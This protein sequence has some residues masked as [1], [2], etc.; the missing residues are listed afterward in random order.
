M[1]SLQ[2]PVL[3]DISAGAQVFGEDVSGVDIFDAHLKFELASGAGEGGEIVK[4]AFSE[5]LFADAPETDVSGVIFFIN[6][7]KSGTTISKAIQGGILNGKLKQ[8]GQ[9]TFG[10]STGTG[11][12]TTTSQSAGTAGSEPTNAAW[13]K[14]YQAP[15]IPLPNFGIAF[16]S[17]ANTIP[18]L[19]ANQRYYTDP[20]C[21][22][23]GTTFGRALIRLM[24]TSLM[25]HPFAQAFIKNEDQII[26]DI[27]E[28]DI[29]S[30]IDDKLFK[31]KVPNSTAIVDINEVN[32][33]VHDD[34]V[35]YFGDGSSA[36]T[37][38]G[39]AK[40]NADKS[41]GIHNDILQQLYEQLLGSA[42]ERFDLS[43]NGTTH[44]ENIGTDVS[45]N[46][47]DAGTCNPTRL[48]FRADDTMSFYF[49][50][51]VALQMD[52]G[53]DISPQTV[54]DASNTNVN[55]EQAV[56]STYSA[57]ATSLSSIFFNPRHRW[58]SHG[59]SFEDSNSNG[60]GEAGA[61]FSG[62]HLTHGDVSGNVIMT[63]TNLQHTSSSR[64]FFDAHVWRIL[65]K[66]T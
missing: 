63:G 40:A 23:D 52:D 38:T 33:T 13:T 20:I 30:Q 2:L 54:A 31:G 43:N 25:G 14:R 46:D 9:A 41:D 58:I 29:G 26:R 16:D 55:N 51:R 60:P 53:A 65:V 42:P 3:F 62:A 47:A 59:I 48:P 39:T 34:A 17:T 21:D 22:G 12:S 57:T 32:Q 35:R 49:R 66:L 27:S 37:A 8:A 1:V 15:G 56:A 4:D 24:A 19:D 7:G 36:G 64:V 50:P 10:T 18:A 44:T 28:N 5:I 61:S 6:K 11:A 45:A